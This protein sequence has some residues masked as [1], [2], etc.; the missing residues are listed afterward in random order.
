[1]AK[2]ANLST[3]HTYTGGPSLTSRERLKRLAGGEPVDRPAISFWRHFPSQ[4]QDPRQLA[5]ATIDF[6]NEYRLDLVKLMPSGMYSVVDYGVATGEPD[7]VTGARARVGGSIGSVADVAAL[8]GRNGMGPSLK[9]ELEAAAAVRQAVSAD[10][11]VIETIFSPL[12]MLAKLSPEPLTSTLTELGDR[13]RSVLDKLADDVIAFAEASL[14]GGVD[15]FFYATQW[16]NHELDDDAV[17]DEY[18]VGYDERILGALR[19]ASELLMLHLH[20]SLPRFELAGRLPVDWVNWEDRDSIPSLAAASQAAPVGLAAGLPRDAAPYTDKHVEQ[21][22][23]RY[24]EDAVVATGGDRLLLAPGCVLH[25]DVR[26]DV[27][28][29]LRRS[30][31]GYGAASRER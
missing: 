12:T 10:V 27:Q 6:Q 24:V 16:A 21:A 30:V 20:G 25:Q 7:P 8:A 23:A 1:M 2:A 18:G 31:D 4:D 9:A 5:R 26:P 13:A 3:E 17:Y 14:R 28:H 22:C 29:A 15:G 19:P 11:P